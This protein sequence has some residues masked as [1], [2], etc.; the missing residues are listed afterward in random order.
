MKKLHARELSRNQLILRFDVIL[1]HDWPIEQCLLHGRVFF[2]GKTKSQCFDLFIHLLIKQITNTC[3][4]HF[5]RSYE[6]ALDGNK[7]MN[8]NSPLEI[9]EFARAKNPLGERFVLMLP[10]NRKR[11]SFSLGNTCEDDAIFSLSKHSEP[12]S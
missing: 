2:G 10:L 9:N 3:P 11:T 8:E 5:S 12:N 7:N 6:I 1:E 4:N